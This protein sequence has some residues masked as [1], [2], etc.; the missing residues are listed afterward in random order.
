MGNIGT[1]EEIATLYRRHVGM[2]YQLCLMLLKKYTRCRRCH[3][4]C[5]SQGDRVW[6]TLS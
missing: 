4:D 3:P 1:G 6:E 5:L 2:V